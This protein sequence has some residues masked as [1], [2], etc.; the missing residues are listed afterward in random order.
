M[1]NGEEKREFRRLLLS[2]DDKTVAVFSLT[3]YSEEIIRADIV[4]L[5]EGGMGLKFRMRETGIIHE[6]DFLKLEE[7]IGIAPLGALSGTEMEIR[8]VLHYQPSRG[9]R[10]GCQFV[11]LSAD[12]QKLIR[13]YITERVQAEI[14]RQDEQF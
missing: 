4:N 13:E 9:V 11:N 7:L 5:S 8:W 10:A 3:S 6:G 14:R 12:K 1:T 2:A